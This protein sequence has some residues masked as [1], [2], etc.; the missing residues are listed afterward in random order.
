MS[1]LQERARRIRAMNIEQFAGGES[2]KISAK[3]LELYAN[4]EKKECYFLGLVAFYGFGVKFGGCPL[5]VK[6]FNDQ[7]VGDNHWV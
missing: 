1:S 3:F 5:S 2:T 4:N 6:R 7:M